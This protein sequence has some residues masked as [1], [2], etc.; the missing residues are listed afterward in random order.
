MRTFVR[1]SALGF[2]SSLPLGCAVAL[3][4]GILQYQTEG[5]DFP[6]WLVGVLFSAAVTVHEAGHG[7]V[8]GSLGVPVEAVRVHW[9]GL[10]IEVGDASPVSRLTASVAGPLAAAASGVGAVA[11]WGAAPAAA[12]YFV[13]ALAHGV[14]LLLPGGDA[15]A[16]LSAVRELRGR[17]FGV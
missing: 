16:A 5:V 7:V 13:F 14:T 8:L 3:G 12:I 10:G 15:S 6:L 4:L 2:V 17:P 1:V 11:I 9:A